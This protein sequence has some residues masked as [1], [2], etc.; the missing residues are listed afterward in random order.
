MRELG[1]YGS[2]R[3]VP[4]NG[5][6]YRDR[7]F[8]NRR[9][10]GACVGL[11]PQPYDSG[12]SHL[13]R[14]ISKQGNRWVRTQLIETVWQWLLYQPGTALTRWFNRAPRARGPPA[15]RGGSQ[16]SQSHGDW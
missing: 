8:N 5:H 10:G 12:E 15:G 13:D 2:E 6:S 4:S 3:G 14:G 1:T 9:Q 7:Q 16:S 11:V